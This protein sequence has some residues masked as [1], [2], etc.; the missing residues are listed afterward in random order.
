MIQIRNV[1]KT[2]YNNDGSVVLG[3][4]NISLQLPKNGLIFINGTSGAVKTTLINSICGIDKV[5][6]G[7]YY[8]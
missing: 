3:L 2:Y 8:Y 5:D 7:I 1:S 4:D 6:S